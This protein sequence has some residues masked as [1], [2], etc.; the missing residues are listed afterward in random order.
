MSLNKFSKLF[1][2]LDSNNSINEKIEILSNYFSSNSPSE[3]ASTIFILLGKSNKR[4]ISGKKLRLFFS[5][6]FD[7]PLWLVDICYSK[8]G[9][10]AE[11][12]Y[13]LLKLH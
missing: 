6:L 1:T 12:I 9:D 10:S 11:V 13:L 7:L 2:D 3:N 4:Y 5:E 8:V